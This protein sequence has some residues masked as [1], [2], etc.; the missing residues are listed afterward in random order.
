MDNLKNEVAELSKKVGERLDG[1]GNN[2]KETAK[3]L[4][5]EVKALSEK[6]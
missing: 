4:T 1:A 5:R 6:D 2:M 3:K